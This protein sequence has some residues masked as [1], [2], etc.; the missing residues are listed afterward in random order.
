MEIKN[1]KIIIIILFINFSIL[2]ACNFVA[3]E[4]KIIVSK[5]K[6][7]VTIY[8]Y[9]LSLDKKELRDSIVTYIDTI[10]L[11]N[12]KNRIYVLNDSIRVYDSYAIEKDSFFLENLYCPNLDTIQIEYDN[13]LFKIIK[14]DYN[15]ENSCDEEMFVYWNYDYGLI[16][17]YNYPWGILILFDKETKK[18]FAKEIFYNYI[19]DKET[20]SVR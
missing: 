11:Y 7:I 18:G 6:E 14:S 20:S 2:F 13:Q 12:R 3:K 5:T 19:L 1:K 17:L 9:Q 15:K 16:A 10:N 8:D 4:N